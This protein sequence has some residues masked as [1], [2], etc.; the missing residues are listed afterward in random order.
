MQK[1]LTIEDNLIIAEDLR[2]K[3]NDL[4]YEVVGNAINLEDVLNYFNKSEIHLLIVDI[5]LG[6]EESGIDL[7]KQVLKKH[8]APVIYL[9]AKSESLIVKK[10]L[11]TQP[12]AYLLKPF[13]LTEFA[14]HVELALRNFDF[15]LKALEE[16]VS[17]D[18][19][20]LKDAIFIP[21][22]QMHIRIDS[23]DIYA[24][25]ADGSY[26]KIITKGKKYQ[27]ASNLKNF[28]RQ[29]SNKQFLRISRKHL[30]N[31]NY[32]TKI[33]G[34]TIYQGERTYQFPKHKRQE[35]LSRF[36][37]LKSKEG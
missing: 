4:G 27:V 12:A 32:I 34:N 33:N 18:L 31:A 19:K 3:L 8:Q 1:I 17:D 20:V 15:R 5:L 36:N 7:V 6:S 29:F 28:C 37:I 14:I 26:V 10:A 2:E 16:S 25:E 9:T 22:Q 11:Q 21:D 30:I 23:H 24:I 35:I 13:D